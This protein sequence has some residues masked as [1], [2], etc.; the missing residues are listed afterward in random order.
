MAIETYQPIAFRGFGRLYVNILLCPASRQR[1]QRRYIPPPSPVILY[2]TFCH[3]ITI[4]CNYLFPTHLEHFNT[5]VFYFSV[6][7]QNASWHWHFIRAPYPSSWHHDNFHSYLLSQKKKKIV[8]IM[9]QKIGWYDVN[10]T[11]TYLDISCYD[12][13][14]SEFIQFIFASCSNCTQCSTPYSI[15]EC[16]LSENP[17]RIIF[18]APRY[19]P[20]SAGAS[21]CGFVDSAPYLKAGHI[22]PRIG[23]AWTHMKLLGINYIWMKSGSGIKCPGWTALE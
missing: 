8:Q 23:P 17:T 19:T 4:H 10:A 9:L 2:K 7:W 6:L 11:R 14:N 5:K 12:K 21:W 3:S 18:Y 15:Y 1:R 20:F 13:L 16:S 22:M